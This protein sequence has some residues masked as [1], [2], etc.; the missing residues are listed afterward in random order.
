[1]RRRGRSSFPF[2]WIAPMILIGIIFVLWT[3]VQAIG[4]LLANFPAIVVLGLLA[5]GVTRMFRRSENGATVG[6][7]STIF[8]W[9]GEER[10]QRRARDDSPQSTAV[11]HA[12]NRAGNADNNLD[13]ELLDIGLLVYEDD[14]HPKIFRLREDPP[15]P[16]H[17]PPFLFA[18]PRTI[19]DIKHPP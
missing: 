2:P 15:H 8:D 5:V 18:D 11:R 17:L 19:N 10:R 14:T 4:G 9:E 1:M 6:V 13:V 16:T 3:I 7:R 12:L